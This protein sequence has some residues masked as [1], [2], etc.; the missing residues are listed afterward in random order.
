MR[1]SF[2]EFADKHLLLALG[3]KLQLDEAGRGREGYDVDGLDRTLGEVLRDHNDHSI[4]DVRRQVERAAELLFPSVF[5]SLGLH[6][7]LSGGS[8]QRDLGVLGKC[9][10]A[11]HQVVALH[12]KDSLLSEHHCLVVYRSI[13][14]AEYHATLD[15]SAPLNLEE[16]ARRNEFAVNCAK[17]KETVGDALDE[18]HRDRRRRGWAQPQQKRHQNQQAERRRPRIKRGTSYNFPVKF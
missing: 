10:S 7:V 8:L 3:C 14:K 16:I 9:G 11:I 2:P 4:I 5:V 12:G 17:H 13:L 15:L 18:A 1:C 6:A